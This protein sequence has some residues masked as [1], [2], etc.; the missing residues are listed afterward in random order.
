MGPPAFS[1][2]KRG[3]ESRIVRIRDLSS[4]PSGQLADLMAES[5]QAGL[6]FVR[7]LQ[8]DWRSGANQFDRPGETLFVAID[9]TRLLGICGLNVDPYSPSPRRRAST[10][11][12]R[13][14]R[15]SQAGDRQ[16]PGPRG[17]RGR[18]TFL[19]LP[20]T[21]NQRSACGPILRAARISSV[22]SPLV[23][24]ARTQPGVNKQVLQ[25]TT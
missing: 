15:P 8:D 10:T 4:L 2:R 5:E 20:A 24:D 21:A 18:S 16:L 19:R 1:N 9:E 13:L 17:D 12:L 3:V 14:G 11:S 6:Y 23:C 22:R 25:V 7:R